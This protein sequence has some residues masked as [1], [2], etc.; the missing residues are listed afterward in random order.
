MCNLSTKP[1]THAN[2]D[3]SG[4]LCSKRRQ[5]FAEAY[6]HVRTYVIARKNKRLDRDANAHERNCET[7]G[8]GRRAR[9]SNAEVRTL[10]SLILVR[11][12]LSLISLRLFLGLLYIIFLLYWL[13]ACTTRYTLV[14][15]CGFV[16]RTLVHHPP[17]CIRHTKVFFLIV[18]VLPLFPGALFSFLPSLSSKYISDM[19]CLSRKILCGSR[20]NIS[21]VRQSH[22]FPCIFAIKDVEVAVGRGWITVI[23]K[24]N[25]YFLPFRIIFKLN[26]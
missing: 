9:P 5:H 14:A 20:S 24:L 6:T 12:S 21:K 3:I 23:K 1:Y 15:R 13:V 19:R 11:F 22:I 25:F 8:H 7:C 2:R 17:S 18:T 4:F 16:R 26:F 10:F